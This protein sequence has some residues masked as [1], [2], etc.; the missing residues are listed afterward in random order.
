MGMRHVNMDLDLNF[1]TPEDR[2]RSEQILL[3]YLLI[4]TLRNYWFLL[5]NPDYPKLYDTD[6]I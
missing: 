2:W 6:M 3:H 4:L 1:D 5:D